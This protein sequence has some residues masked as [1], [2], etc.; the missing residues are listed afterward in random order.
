M[1]LNLKKTWLKATTLA[2]VVAMGAVFFQGTTQ[3]QKAIDI[4][5]FLP[6]GFVVPS[7]AQG[8]TLAGTTEA[9]VLTINTGSDTDPQFTEARFYGDGSST[10]PIYY[11]NATKTY[12][13]QPGWWRI[14]YQIPSDVYL[15]QRWIFNFVDPNT[16]DWLHNTRVT[17]D[18]DA[19]QLYESAFAFSECMAGNCGPLFTDEILS[20]TDQQ[21]KIRVNTGSET[22][23]MFTEM[24][25][26]TPEW[27]D[28]LPIYQLVASDTQNLSDGW[29]EIT[30][31]IP[32]EAQVETR[33]RFGFVDPNTG[34]WISI[35]R[36][37]IDTDKVIIYENALAFV[38][39]KS[40]DPGDV[41]KLLGGE[42]ALTLKVL[43]GSDFD[44]RFTDVYFYGPE[45]APF[46]VYKL[47]ADSTSLISAG[48][49]QIDFTIPVEADVANRWRFNFV[50]PANGE[51]FDVTK[52]TIVSD[53]I[54][55]YDHA[56][57]FTAY[58]I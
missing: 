12:L 42:T 37:V 43:T 8:E 58:K 16:G 48:L 50:D 56:F 34:A 33:W 9:L 25:L 36:F 4:D 47:Q 14:V 7:I 24:Y 19:I 57:A 38:D 54:E 22:D 45:G 30:Y 31:D 27:G 3:A 29:W 11:L 32:T 20:G 53:F 39:Y 21:I 6:R 17:L 55:L 28:Y 10:L 44:P 41:Q 51:W 2:L 13:V 18:S 26:F 49:W 23:A 40:T 5:Q 35:D 15:A 1:R 52:A 46:E